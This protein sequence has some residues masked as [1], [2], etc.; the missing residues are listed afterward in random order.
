M[1]E[2]NPYYFKH[3]K[4][5]NEKHEMKSFI[6]QCDTNELVE[7]R[8]GS[9]TKNLH[10]QSQINS[11]V[12]VQFPVSEISSVYLNESVKKKTKIVKCKVIFTRMGNI[13]TKLERFDSQIFIECFW[14]DESI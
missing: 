10:L 1:Y 2:L 9:S 7:R 13:N 3:S 8:K 14:D 6:T 5:E 11:L 12:S 4:L